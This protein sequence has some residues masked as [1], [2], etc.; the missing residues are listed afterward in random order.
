[1]KTQNQ[2]VQV[3]VHQEKKNKNSRYKIIS[4]ATII[5][6]KNIKI[7]LIFTIIIQIDLQKIK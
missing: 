4:V 5:L 2:D 3:A 7:L 6:A 1:M